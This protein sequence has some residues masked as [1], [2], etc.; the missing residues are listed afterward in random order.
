MNPFDTELESVKFERRLEDIDSDILLIGYARQQPRKLVSIHDA[1]I[2]E[3]LL[4]TYYDVFSTL[5]YIGV[6]DR[7]SLDINPDLDNIIQ[8]K[9]YHFYKNGNNLYLNLKNF[10]LQLTNYLSLNDICS[11]TKRINNLH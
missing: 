11:F 6:N 7:V 4:G 5:W 1:N 10:K 9:G 3:L 2:R 8:R